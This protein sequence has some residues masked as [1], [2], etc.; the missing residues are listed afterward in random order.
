MVSMWVRTPTVTER[1]TGNGSR[2]TKNAAVSSPTDRPTSESE[3]LRPV[4][5]Q[6]GP[7]RAQQ[8]GHSVIEAQQE[9]S[10]R[11]EAEAPEAGATGFV[12]IVPEEPDRHRVDEHLRERIGSWEHQHRHDASQCRGHQGAGASP[13]QV[14]AT[15][16]PATMKAHDI[17]NSGRRKSPACA[18]AA[19]IQR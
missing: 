10:R 12:H 16:C 17:R 6:D 15:A 4:H 2:P 1:N 19:D 3:G 9:R 14:M 13:H 7:D 5:E 11:P 8:D 18:T